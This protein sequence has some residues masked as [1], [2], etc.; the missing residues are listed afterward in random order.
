MTY[1]R[2][3]KAGSR[4]PTGSRGLEAGDLG[5]VVHGYEGA[6]AFEVEFVSAEG[7][8][9]ALV[10]LTSADVRPLQGAEILHARKLASA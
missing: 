2:M 1:G 4:A 8:T 3:T 10:T 6:D 7:R 9:L 5:A